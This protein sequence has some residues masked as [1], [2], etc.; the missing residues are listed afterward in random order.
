M[1]SLKIRN[2]DNRLSLLLENNR[3]GVFFIEKFE[4][5]DNQLLLLKNVNINRRENHQ[6]H[7]NWY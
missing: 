5:H 3:S 7:K 2:W 4:L 6:L 1:V